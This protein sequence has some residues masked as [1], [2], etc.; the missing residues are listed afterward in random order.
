MAAKGICKIKN[1]WVHQDS[2]W[3]QYDDGKKLEIPAG[4]YA[5]QG[6]SASYRAVARMQGREARCLG[7]FSA[8]AGVGIG[9]SRVRAVENKPRGSEVFD[10]DSD[11]LENRGLT[12]R[13]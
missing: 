9:S 6:F 10:C 2:V 3:V 8:P 12:N 7:A 13:G 5:E 11:R 4:Q 1:G